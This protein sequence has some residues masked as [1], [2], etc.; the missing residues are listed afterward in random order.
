MERMATWQIALRRLEMPI[1]RFL[2][3]FVLPSALAGL[4]TAILLI[5][6]TGGLSEGGLFA[7][8]TGV[9]LVILLPAL[10]GGAAIYFPVLEVNRS[11]I[12]IEKEMHMF[13]TRMGILS[14]GEVGADTIFDI[15]RQMKDYGELAQE[16]KR[17]ETLVDK[18]HTSLPEAARIVAQQSPSPLWTDFLDRMAFSIE[19]GQ[20]IDA[21]MRAEQETVAEQYNTLYDTRLES[22]DTLKE[23]YVSLVSAGLFGLV[24]AG[25]HLVLFEIGNGSSAT[26]I[27]VATR[28]RWLLLAGFLFVVIQLGALFAF[29]ATIPDDQTFAR[30][31]FDTPF[32]LLFRQTWLGAGIVSVFL[33]IFTMYVIIAYWE[34]LTTSWD[35]YGLILL[36]IPFTPLLIPSMLV[37]REENKV[38]RRDEAYPDFI[39]ALGGTAQA[40]S[41][42]PSTTIRALRGIDFGMLD[43]SI[44]RLEKRLLTRIDSERAW[45]YF[46]A[47]AN[48]A[49]ISRYNRIYIEGSQSSGEPAET[50]DMVS[51][52]VTNLLSLRRR[53]SLSA[54]TMWGV[55]FGLLISSVVSL[56]V[57]ISIVLQ[58]GETIAGVAS[59][60]AETTDIGSISDSAGDFVLPVMED[61]TAVQ[62]NIL[63]F[64]IIASILIL[65]QVLAVSFIA[66]RLRGGGFT[67]AVGQMI[68]LL[69]VAA[70]A[71]LVSSFIL[72]G[73]SSM[74]ST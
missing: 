2:L 15:L 36:A 59:S 51:R 72:D 3:L 8:F 60:I 34:G 10:T 74:F 48:S 69:W 55:A 25:I 67:S 40:R 7:G 29:R 38:L 30:D 27:E 16:V 21:F 13:I 9:F 4:I 58:L 31:E 53:R 44:D 73:A 18:W 20:P 37:H 14:L 64:K 62:D 12:K 35:K 61:P 46:A 22:V 6:L 1:P 17:I 11:A 65:V 41:A 19:A 45:D 47:D 33:L 50:A 57:T 68:Q 23:I 71:S 52:S 70:I 26:P 43:E 54:S 56:N 66:T 63:M 24:V 42:E 32:R 28:I 49:V 5:W 39:R